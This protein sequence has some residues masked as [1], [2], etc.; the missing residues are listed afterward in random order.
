M[1]I[2]VYIRAHARGIDREMCRV[3][4]SSI[5]TSEQKINHLLRTGKT[6]AF[7]SPRWIIRVSLEAVNRV[8]PHLVVRRWVQAIINTVVRRQTIEVAIAVR[9]R[10]AVDKRRSRMTKHIPFH[11]LPMHLTFRDH[12]LDPT[13]PSLLSLVLLRVLAR[14]PGYT[15]VSPHLNRLP[16]VV[17][18]VVVEL[19]VVVVVVVLVVVVVVRAV[20]RPST[21]TPTRLDT[22][23]VK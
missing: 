16:R 15:H 22:A 9:E 8:V 12:G 6:G 17:V 18:M 19:V 7:F 10:E 2:T 21:A 3:S 4:V 11:R 20:H 5:D 13:R 14:S 1:K 23:H